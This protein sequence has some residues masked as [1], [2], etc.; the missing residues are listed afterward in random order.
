MAKGGNERL[1][2]R[3]YASLR[4]VSGGI[5]SI[6]GGGVTCKQ[7]ASATTKRPLSL[8]SSP[9]HQIAPF[10]LTPLLPYITYLMARREREKEPFLHSLSFVDVPGGN[11][12]AFVGLSPTAKKGGV[13][14][15][16]IYLYT[17]FNL[18]SL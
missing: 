7:T 2:A 17:P 10:R 16:E 1:S 9:L 13:C 8:S 5:V 6:G 12:V 14:L 3:R 15:P 11:G 4:V 18:E